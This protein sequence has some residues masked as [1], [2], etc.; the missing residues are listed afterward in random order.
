MRIEPEQSRLVQL[1]QNLGN[2][3]AAFSMH[4]L[5]AVLSGEFPLCRRMERGVELDGDAA[6][7]DLAKREGRLAVKGPGL[8]KNSDARAPR[9]INEMLTLFPV[10]QRRH[11]LA[12]DAVLEP[13][14]VAQ[15]SSERP[16][17]RVAVF[18]GGG[19]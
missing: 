15:P 8:D 13:S 7:D 10:G 6:I 14:A 4:Q 5:D 12:I 11:R 2:E 3:I 18:H 19:S 1:R 9:P 17:K 16:Q